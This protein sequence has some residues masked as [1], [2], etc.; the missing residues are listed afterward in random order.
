[1]EDL[2]SR[3]QSM[4]GST[5][6]AARRALNAVFSEN[7]TLLVTLAEQVMRDERAESFLYETLDAALKGR[8]ERF[9]TPMEFV[10]E[11]CKEIV[12]DIS[13]YYELCIVDL[14]VILNGTPEARFALV[15]DILSIRDDYTIICNFIVAG[16]TENV[17]TTGIA[18]KPSSWRSGK[19]G[20]SISATSGAIEWYD[21]AFQYHVTEKGGKTPPTV[22]R[23]R[24]Y[25]ETR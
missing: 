15:T 17:P 6:V 14:T 8:H 24:I 7:S 12:N 9:G 21:H 10:A 5:A 23:F 2:I 22:Y 16:M 1:M 4:T 3:L 13:N 20:T 18:G 25:D 11:E 19:K